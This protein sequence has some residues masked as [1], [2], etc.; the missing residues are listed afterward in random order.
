MT[1]SSVSCPS[2]FFEIF[3]YLV[4][5]RIMRFLILFLALAFLFFPEKA[6]A[7]QLHLSIEPTVVYLDTTPPA[8]AQATFR[9][10]NLS[11]STTTL[12]P[13]LIPFKADDEGKVQLLFSEE[14]NLSTVIKNKLSILDGNSRIDKLE[15]RA[16]ETKELRLFMDVD[17]GDPVGDYYF[18]LVFLAEGSS[19][20]DTSSSSIPGGI[21]MNVMVTIGPKISASGEIEEFG[22][23]TFVSSGP[24]PFALKLKNT[25]NHLIQ[26]EGTISI[27]NMFGKE[28]GKLKLEPQ[29]VLANSSRYLID[30]VQAS[31]SGSLELD[32]DL[33]L[34][35][36]SAVWTE[37]FLMGPYSATATITLEEG[38]A[39]I[40]QTTRFIAFPLQ[41]LVI[42][43]GVI[44]VVL[45]IFL[46]VKL[47]L[48]KKID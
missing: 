39:R 18:S 35:N 40:T 27:K 11:D 15:L 45:G 47:R 8:N 33:K 5:N 19:L 37:K 7:Q 26:P 6:H 22:T 38:G 10:R 9:L 12:T 2:F 32:H 13:R 16:G 17:E 43:S 46:R 41:I 44:F 1:Y 34:D 23:N 24:V 29:Y 3:I 14:K 28:V 42:I 31:T 21:A 36:P 48:R 20:D 4:D 30:S 25:G